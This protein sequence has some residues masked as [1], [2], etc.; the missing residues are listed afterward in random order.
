MVLRD[1]LTNNDTWGFVVSERTSLGHGTVYE[2]LIRLESA[3]VVDIRLEER[4]PGLQRRRRNLISLTEE[5]RAWAMDVTSRLE[6]GPTEIERDACIKLAKELQEDAGKA[7]GMADN[8]A[9]KALL[10]EREAAYRIVAM[11]IKARG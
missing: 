9:G 10:E 6:Y 2:I 7:A 11:K 5:G 3:K 8:G 4:T 1:L